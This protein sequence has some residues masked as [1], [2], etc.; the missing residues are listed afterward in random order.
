MNIY[1]DRPYVFKNIWRQ[2]LKGNRPNSIWGEFLLQ[3]QLLF[4][5]VYIPEWGLFS[6]L[7]VE[8]SSNSIPYEGFTDIKRTVTDDF[9][10]L[11]LY[12]MNQLDCSVFKRQLYVVCV[13]HPIQVLA[14]A[15]IN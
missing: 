11:G 15:Q 6:M 14:L 9:S 10:E 7:Y 5:S 2:F 8:N 12:T 4:I 1:G 13:S 3:N